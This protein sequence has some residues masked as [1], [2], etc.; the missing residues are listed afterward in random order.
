MEEE[1]EEKQ[2][3]KLKE[4]GH[5]SI[6]E[7]TEA[8]VQAMSQFN[9]RDEEIKNIKIENQKLDEI[10]KKKEEEIYF[11]ENKNKELLDIND[12]LEKQL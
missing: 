12:K 4:T 6:E 2:K 8:I 1:R 10:I 7:N 3:Y 9:M 11:F 5:P